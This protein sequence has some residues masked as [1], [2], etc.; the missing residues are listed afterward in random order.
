MYCSLRL[1]RGVR[2]FGTD[3]LASSS[4]ANAGSDTLQLTHSKT[5]IDLRTTC[6][7]K[8]FSST[9]LRTIMQIY[10]KEVKYVF[11]IS[12]NWCN[13]TLFQSGIH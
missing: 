10:T 9:R 2:Y 12:S 7:K 5:N 3:N 4:T 6:M 1:L 13:F 8:L 11:N